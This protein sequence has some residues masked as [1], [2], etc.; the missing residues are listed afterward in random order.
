M[1]Q[2]QSGASRLPLAAVLVVVLSGL[3]TMPV[4]AAAI[5]VP[6]EIT[7]AALSVGVIGLAVFGIAVGIKLY[8]WIKAAL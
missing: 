1:K 3:A 6:T 8:K 4:Q 5:T 7:D 2:L